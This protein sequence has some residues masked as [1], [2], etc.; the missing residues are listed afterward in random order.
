[1]FENIP[2]MK[3]AVR[4]L[5]G[6]EEIVPPGIILAN[7]RPEWYAVKRER[8]WATS[9]TEG[10][11]AGRPQF[12]IANE[13]AVGGLL[14]V[15]VTSISIFSPVAGLYVLTLD[16]AQGAAPT[17]NLT[18]DFRNSGIQSKNRILNTVGASGIIIETRNSPAGGPDFQFLNLPVILTQSHRLS[19]FGVAASALNI[20]AAGYE[21]NARPEELA[22]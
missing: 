2:R 16:A 4:R 15:V 19:V 12:D 13:P 5:W 9:V 1:M 22:I 17:A 7:D 21:F 6:E 11:G 14:I 20:N 8:L 3:E 10:A 18:R